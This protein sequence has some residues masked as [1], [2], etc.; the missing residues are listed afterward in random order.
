MSGMTSFDDLSFVDSRGCPQMPPGAPRCLGIIWET[1]YVWESLGKQCMFW[2]PW[3]NNVCLGIPGKTMY[4][5]EPLRKQCMVGNPLGN[6]VCLGI[7]GGNNVCLGI[8]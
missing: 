8:P 5:W 7:P 2:N 6:N 4:V 3:G 1:M